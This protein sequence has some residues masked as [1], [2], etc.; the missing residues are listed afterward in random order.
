M[1]AVTGATGYVGSALIPALLE[2]GHDVRAL[3]RDPRRVAPRAGL[4]V[5]RADLL[6]PAGLASALEG[7]QAAYY[8]VHS[9]DRAGGRDFAA[10]DRTAASNFGRAAREAGVERIVYLGG[11]VP[12][13]N[14]SA[15]LGSR[16][17][18]ERILLEAVPASTALRTSIVIGARSFPFRLLVRL[19][20]RL[21]VIPLPPWHTFSTQPLAER[22]M[23]R[24]LVRAVEV[25]AAAGR[26][27]DIAGPDRVTYAQLI[28]RIAEEMGVGRMPLDVFTALPP[29]TGAIVAAVTELPIDTVRPLMGS[30][31]FDVVPR[32]DE[33][34]ALFGIRPLPLTRAIDRALAEWE[35]HEPLAAR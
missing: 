21:R 13:A 25:E 30:L 22:D 14:P 11:I 32:S 34:N 15:H 2:R 26:S 35:R 33:A 18:V 19:V 4:D 20:E 28:E 6:R 5:A 8:L 29:V 23:I 27:L 9:M 17:E 7:C 16:L 3:A 10:R 1:H 31:Q 12:P 24:F